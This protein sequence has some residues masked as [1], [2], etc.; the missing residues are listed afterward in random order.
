MLESMEKDG[1]VPPVA[2]P[3][4]VEEIVVTVTYLPKNIIL[5]SFL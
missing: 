1:D 4:R 5:I 2:L 3:D